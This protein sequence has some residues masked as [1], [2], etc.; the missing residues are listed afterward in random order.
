MVL[1]IMCFVYSNLFGIGST[2]ETC[3]IC[4]TKLFRVGKLF[5]IKNKSLPCDIILASQQS[6]IFIY[7]YCI[8]VFTFYKHNI[9]ERQSDRLRLYNLASVGEEREWL[10][11]VLLSSGSDTS[12]DDETPAGKELRLQRILKE[13]RHQNKYARKYYKDPGVSSN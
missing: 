11:D 9:L 13:R 6:H 8:M 4:K 10:R 2:L 7:L 12:S 5:K 3:S 1:P